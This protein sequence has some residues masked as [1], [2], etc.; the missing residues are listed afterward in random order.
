MRKLGMV[1]AMLLAGIAGWLFSEHVIEP[2]QTRRTCETA[3]VEKFAFEQ[4]LKYQ[5][6]CQIQDGRQAMIDYY[7]NKN[8]IAANCATDSAGGFLPEIN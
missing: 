3:A 7:E 8:W 4:C 6:A 2:A 1:L 5:P